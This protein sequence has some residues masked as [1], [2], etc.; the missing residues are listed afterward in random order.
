MASKPKS[1]DLSQKEISLLYSEFGEDFL[2]KRVNSSYPT[3]AKVHTFMHE[4]ILN[5]IPRDSS[6]IVDLGCGDGI[7]TCKF[8]QKGF[9]KIVGI[10]VSESN[11]A[12]AHKI[13]GQNQ[14]VPITSSTS[15]EVGDV[16]KTRFSRGSFDI[17]V[18][19]HVLEHLKVFEDGLAEQKRLAK[20]YVVV[21]LPTVW[22]PLSWTLLGGGNYWKHGKWGSAR[23]IIG[24]FRVLK[25]F[26]LFDIG[27]DE[28][29]YSAIQGVPHIFF[30]PSRIAKRLECGDWRVSS[31]YPQATGFPWV[32][33]SIKSPRKQARN[34]FGTIFILAPRLK[35]EL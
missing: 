26:F 12:S 33:S 34:G 10:D 6:S 1:A 21:A 16:T 27:V 17:S 7:L 2:N 30:Y 32:Q 14:D 35:P 18:T 22:S 9:T 24:L 4:S 20:K 28:K 3:R 29:S 5:V 31:I 11:I 8:S 15:F 19:S 23:M 25:G 13:L